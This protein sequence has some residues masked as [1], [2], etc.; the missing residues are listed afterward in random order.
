MANFYIKPKF[1][2]TKKDFLTEWGVRIIS[3]KGHDTEKPK[4]Y[5]KINWPEQHGLEVYVPNDRKVADVEVELRGIYIGDSATSNLEQMKAFLRGNG[6]LNYSDTFRNIDFDIV[7]EQYIVEAE[8][9][10]NGLQFVQFK[11]T[12]TKNINQ[13][14][15][16]SFLDEYTP[17]DL[18]TLYENIINAANIALNATS[19][20]KAATDLAYIAI[21]AADSATISAIEATNNALSMANN[22]PMI[23]PVS[24]VDYW[25]YWNYALNQYVNSWKASRGEKGDTPTAE[26]SYNQGTGEITISFE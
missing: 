4:E 16:S 9:N 5:Y 21:A 18:E 26:M 2:E 22:P 8:R 13:N 12:F 6:I 7:Y 14:I 3:V 17:E 11:L 20:A 24:G 19:D 25:H 23:I 15:D 1:S 10:R